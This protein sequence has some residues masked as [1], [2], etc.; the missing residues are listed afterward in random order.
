VDVDDDVARLLLTS[1]FDRRDRAAVTR[2]LTST[3]AAMVA[4]ALALAG[5]SSSGHKACLA[6][7]PGSGG[8]A[9][10]YPGAAKCPNNPLLG[11][12]NPSRLKVHSPCTR[13][14]GTVVVIDIKKDGDQHLD[15]RPD[16]GYETL[17]DKGNL[18][19]QSGSMVV[20]IM[21][22]QNFPPLKVGDHIGVMGT[23]VHDTHNDWNEIHP[24]WSIAYR[25]NAGEITSLP[26][27]IP[28]YECA[29]DA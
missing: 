19:D 5:C 23:F 10:T 13:I 20:E 18:K 25:N 27:R 17:L 3:A 8:L 12:Y 9:V 29:S 6:K 24:V 22:G 21:P 4:L 7:H 11:V 26:P 15:L 16:P 28:E 1:P 14:H 2:R